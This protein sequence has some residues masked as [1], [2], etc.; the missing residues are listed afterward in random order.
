MY[1]MDDITFKCFVK[2]KYTI[3]M[4]HHNVCIIIKLGKK[5]RGNKAQKQPPEVFCK[6]GVPKFLRTP[7]LTEHLQWLLLKAV[8][9]CI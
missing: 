6:K 5:A 9:L 8:R 7:F 3:I 1:E 2:R 4:D